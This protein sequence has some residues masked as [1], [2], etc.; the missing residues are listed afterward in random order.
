MKFYRRVEWIVCK[1]KDIYLE[2][3]SENSKGLYSLILIL[4][5][6]VQLVRILLALQYTS[7]S[8]TSD[9]LSPLMPADRFGLKPVGLMAV[10]LNKMSIGS[11][12]VRY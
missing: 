1:K 7:T 6:T 12:D 3:N 11:F 4:Q 9:E 5:D 10:T 8:V 2:S